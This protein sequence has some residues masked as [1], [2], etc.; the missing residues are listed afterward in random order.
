MKNSRVLKLILV[1]L[2]LLLTFMGLWRVT[3]PVGFYAMSGI[4]LGS[5]V[6]ML[7][8]VRGAGGAWDC[9]T[10]QLGNRWIPWR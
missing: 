8:E 10:T 3:N 5:G 6:S 1:V 2:G 7:N 9:T 4:V